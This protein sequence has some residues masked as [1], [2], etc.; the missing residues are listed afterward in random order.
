M[1]NMHCTRSQDHS[2]KSLELEECNYKLNLRCR[3]IIWDKR[4]TTLYSALL[5]AALPSEFKSLLAIL[6]GDRAHSQ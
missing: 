3:S 6:R 2:E 4:L 1:Y 5:T